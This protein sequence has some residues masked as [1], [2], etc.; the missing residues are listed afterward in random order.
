MQSLIE[1]NILFSLPHFMLFILLNILSLSKVELSFYSI[2]LV[3]GYYSL[4]MY[5]LSK[6][7][8][9]LKIVKIN[10]LDFQL[11]IYL[12][13]IIF[14]LLLIIIN[15]IHFINH[16]R[17]LNLLNL[18]IPIPI[19]IIILLPLIIPIIIHPITLIIHPITLISLLSLLIL[20]VFIK[21]I[22]F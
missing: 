22:I 17:L 18:L 13:F 8:L 2:L 14:T 5:L 19:L 3:L 21:I 16:F 1:N 7:L 12:K 4:Q 15:L 11:Q 9:L 20:K 6:F 10:L